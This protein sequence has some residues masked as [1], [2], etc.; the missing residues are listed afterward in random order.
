MRWPSDRFF[1]LITFR[2]VTIPSKIRILIADD[3]T[4]VRMAISTL[5]RSHPGLEVVGEARDGEEAMRLASRHAP[6]IVLLELAMPGLDCVAVVRGIV[7]GV[8]GAK[9]LV[10]TGAGGE[11]RLFPALRAGAVGFLFK[12]TSA[13]EL[14]GAIHQ[15]ADSHPV[16]SAGAAR[17]LI[18]ELSHDPGEALLS[19]PLTSREL[20]VLRGMAERMSDAEIAQTLRISM[21]SLNDSISSI[22]LKLNISRRT[23]AILYA[24][25]HGIA[26]GYDR[27]AS[28]RA[29]LIDSLMLE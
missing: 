10:L 23:Q 20:E 4:V 5:L 24:M 8:S 12:D 17:K 21:R 16:F 26:A 25:K 1:A 22:F 27:K 14:I 19:E 29:A 3:S 9:V 6:D 18:E 7:E 28:E 11:H 15:V 2:R 13:E